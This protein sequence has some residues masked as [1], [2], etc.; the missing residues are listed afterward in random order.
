MQN[1]LNRDKN[2]TDLLFTKLDN[3]TLH[4]FSVQI[5]T[6]SGTLTNTSKDRETT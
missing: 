5:I 6:L 2:C 1:K 3:T 4:H